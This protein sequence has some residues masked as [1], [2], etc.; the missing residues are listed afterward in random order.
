MG[1]ARTGPSVLWRNRCVN[2]CGVKMPTVV[3]KRSCRAAIPLRVPGTHRSTIPLSA[4]KQVPIRTIIRHLPFIAPRYGSCYTHDLHN[5][6]HSSCGGRQHHGLAGNA[7]LPA[8]PRRLASRR[9]PNRTS[10]GDDPRRSDRHRPNHSSNGEY[11]LG[12]SDCGALVCL[13]GRI[14]WGGHRM[15]RCSKYW[16]HRGCSCHHGHCRRTGP[17]G[18]APRPLRRPSPQAS[19]LLP[20]QGAGNP[21]AGRRGLV[22][23]AEAV[24]L[25]LL[26]RPEPKVDLG[27]RKGKGDDPEHLPGT[28]HRSH[29]SSEAT[30]HSGHHREK[31]QISQVSN[32]R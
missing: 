17:H 27:S 13:P 8:Q 18:N 7:Q 23:A 2:R 10:R 19:P 11:Q 16:R 9:H 1:P 32:R 4:Q 28:R 15:G 14:P 5:R 26:G 20:A 29:G 12:G 24:V 25:G 30:G 22:H 6:S 3:R 21:S 31:E